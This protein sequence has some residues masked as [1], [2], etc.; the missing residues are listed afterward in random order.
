M[1]RYYVEPAIFIVERLTE[2]SG[3]TLDGYFKVRLRDGKMTGMVVY[4][5]SKGAVIAVRGSV[6]V[7]HYECWRVLEV[8]GNVNKAGRLKF[9]TVTCG[10]FI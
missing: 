7:G 1:K 2:N 4:K 9:V 3:G 8:V 10:R 5:N 6:F